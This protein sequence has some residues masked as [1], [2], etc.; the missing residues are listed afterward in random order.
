MRQQGRTLARSAA[1][2]RG[3]RAPFFQ[4]TPPEQAREHRDRR[5][6]AAPAGNPALA[7]GR[8]AAPGTM[9]GT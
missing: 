1:R 3:A 2:W 6:E 5:E 8:Q 9:P 7:V 4:E